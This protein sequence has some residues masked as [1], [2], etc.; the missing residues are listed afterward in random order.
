[1]TIVVKKVP[2]DRC[3]TEVS[4][5]SMEILD[6]ITVNIKGEEPRPARGCEQ[7]FREWTLTQSRARECLGSRLEESDGNSGGVQ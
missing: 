2:C 7:C 3:F 5:A 1:M 4:I 6:G